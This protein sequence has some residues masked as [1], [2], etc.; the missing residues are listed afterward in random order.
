M[1]TA[2]FIDDRSL[3]LRPDDAV[4]GLFR[5]AFENHIQIRS[6]P[7]APMPPS[8]AAI[9]KTTKIDLARYFWLG[10]IDAHQGWY[11][12]QDPP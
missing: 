11:L 2:G 6:D 5:W 7:D 3:Q 12:F 4:V 9:F 1:T 10:R 8:M